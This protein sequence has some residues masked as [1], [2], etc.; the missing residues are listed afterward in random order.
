MNL[1]LH[2]KIKFKRDNTK[3]LPHSD[4]KKIGGGIVVVFHEQSIY[5]YDA[6][7]HARINF[8]VV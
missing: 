6:L 4:E 2:L 3:F 5:E 8:N 7:H 1:L